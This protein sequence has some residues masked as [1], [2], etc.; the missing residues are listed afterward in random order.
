[1]ICTINIK[2]DND[3]FFFKD[4]KSLLSG[5]K[6]LLSSFYFEQLSISASMA[7]ERMAFFYL[8]IPFPNLKLALAQI[9]SWILKPKLS[10]HRIPVFACRRHVRYCSRVE[11][12]PKTEDEKAW[13]LSHTWH[14][15]GTEALKFLVPVGTLLV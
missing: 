7:S 1:M 3:F 6:M 2:K 13:H 4:G 10:W 15:K 8:L 5:Y 11:L 9:S 12:L 14:L